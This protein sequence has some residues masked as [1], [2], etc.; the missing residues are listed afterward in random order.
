MTKRQS[1]V[2]KAALD[3]ARDGFA[4]FPCGSDKTPRV[5]N[6]FH[7]A[8]TDLNE[9]RAMFGD[10]AS[11]TIGLAVPDGII[12]ID[13]DPRNGGNETM[14]ALRSE[15]GRSAFPRTLTAKTGGGGEHRWYTVADDETRLRGKLGT[16]VD[17][18]R[19][20]KG[21]VIAPPSVSDSGA[22]EWTNDADM[23]PAPEWMLE[24]LRRPEPGARSTTP[25]EGGP[26]MFP[27]ADGTAYGEAALRHELDDLAT[28][29]PGG[30]N[31]ALNAAAFSLAQLIAGGELL[32]EPVRAKLEEAAALLDLT[33]H[34]TEL[35][36][37]S[38]FEAGFQE[39]RNAPE[40]PDQHKTSEG[41]SARLWE[42]DSAPE[43]HDE[44]FWLDWS[45]EASDDAYILEPVLPR[46]A[47]VLVYGATEA[48]KS[49]VFNALGAQASCQGFSVSVYSL[50][51]PPNV[52]R[53][54]L[55]RLAPCGELFRLSNQL[56]NLADERQARALMERE[57]GRD[58]V[59]ID[60]YSH[61]FAQ[62]YDSGDGNAKAIE[63]AR[64]I[65]WLIKHTGS[66]FVVI[67][68]T[69]FERPE[70]PRD[71]S[72][73]RQQVDVA[74]GMRRT[75]PWERGKP[76]YFEMVNYKSARFANPFTLRGRILGNEGE[77]LTLDWD[78]GDDLKWGDV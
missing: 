28:A 55:Q 10:D 66:T 60:T 3:Y 18:K 12:I 22:Y 41:T 58:L 74:I 25:R 9:V 6:G 77:P 1:A 24:L 69:G 2:L 59:I 43:E 31:D 30:R 8:T 78:N 32:E 61:A 13:T 38:A 44:H 42:A 16:G 36:I 7:D 14:K 56:L 70:E 35:T 57:R 49:M 52:D 40:L 47:Y 45:G 72:A 34:E 65:R 21:Y 17:V 62:R 11:L 48:S 67:D 20:G 76:A 54:R 27:F 53:A 4:V 29:Q 5:K 73:K 15:H 19:A 39:P 46:E 33:P 23:V 64:V 37:T 68:H 51:N 71:A 50:E 26:A 75:R 63:F